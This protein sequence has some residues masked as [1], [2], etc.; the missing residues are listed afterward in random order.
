MQASNMLTKAQTSHNGASA[1]FHWSL[2]KEKCCIFLFDFL[3]AC[4]CECLCMDI[5]LYGCIP[6]LDGTIVSPGRRQEA[7]DTGGETFW[8]ILCS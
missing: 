8:G 7:E 3:L 2:W 4:I 1:A 5:Q 6:S